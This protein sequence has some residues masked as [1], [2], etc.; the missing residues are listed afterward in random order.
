MLCKES[1]PSVAMN[2]VRHPDCPFMN[3]PASPDGKGGLPWDRPLSGNIKLRDG[4]DMWVGSDV[5][6][7]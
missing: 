4:A 7:R 3:Y 2:S 5:V 6:D 1:V